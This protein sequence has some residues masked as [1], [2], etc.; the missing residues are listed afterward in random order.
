M[1]PKNRSFILKGEPQSGIL[2]FNLTELEPK[3][4][5]NVW[6]LA[7]SSLTI[8]YKEGEVHRDYTI[9]LKCNFVEKSSFIAVAAFTPTSGT[10]QTKLFVP[11]WYEM[12]FVANMFEIAVHDILAEKVVDEHTLFCIQVLFHRKA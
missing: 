10:V 5:N 4:R 12:D 7:I 8:A 1:E 6:A 2:S 9:G 11:V 3:I